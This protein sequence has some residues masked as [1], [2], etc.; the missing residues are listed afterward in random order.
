MDTKYIVA[1]VY[2]SFV[3]LSLIK[4]ICDTR[5]EAKTIVDNL[6]DDHYISTIL[7]ASEFLYARKIQILQLINHMNEELN[8]IN[9]VLERH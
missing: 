3:P 6:E 9:A 7:N 4:N 2:D 8:T 1:E 5:E